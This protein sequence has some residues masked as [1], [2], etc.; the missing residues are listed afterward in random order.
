MRPTGADG[1]G[2]PAKTK[3]L[4]PDIY[5]FVAQKR[6]RTFLSHFF[7]GKVAESS[8]IRNQKQPS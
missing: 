2:E 6:L 4:P 1:E 5:N 8:G 7:T 3:L